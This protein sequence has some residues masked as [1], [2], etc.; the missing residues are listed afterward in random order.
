MPTV[1]CAA[2][3]KSS[4][5]LLRNEIND[6]DFLC[7]LLIAKRQFFIDD[8]NSEGRRRRRKFVLQQL[9]AKEFINARIMTL[10]HS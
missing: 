4:A 6:V 7:A 5:R 1:T 9:P 8:P 3:F 2:F 10:N